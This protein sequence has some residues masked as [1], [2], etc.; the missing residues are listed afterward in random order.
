MRIT[1]IQNN[2]PIHQTTDHIMKLKNTK[3]TW[4]ALILLAFSLLLDLPD[5]AHTIATHDPDYL[6]TCGAFLFMAVATI[7]GMVQLASLRKQ[8]HTFA[9]SVKPRG[10]SIDLQRQGTSPLRQEVRS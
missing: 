1:E 10:E 3:F 4:T 8:A 5:I 7:L 9:K 6:L 2:K